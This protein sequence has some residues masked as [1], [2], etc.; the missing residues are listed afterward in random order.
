MGKY[1]KS[2]KEAYYSGMGYALRGQNRNIKFTSNDVKSSF[3]AGCAAGKQK[4][5][6]NEKKYP[7]RKK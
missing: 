4:A 7:F 3:L 5:L 2:Q 1:T 6:N